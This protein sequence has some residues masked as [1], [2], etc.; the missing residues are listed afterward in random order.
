MYNYLL[1]KQT[2]RSIYLD[3]IYCFGVISPFFLF[4][5][6]KMTV[7]LSRDLTGF[8]VGLDF[9]NSRFFYRRYSSHL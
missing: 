4:L 9:Q 7:V 1:H 3:V 8:V 2:I 5:A 6:S